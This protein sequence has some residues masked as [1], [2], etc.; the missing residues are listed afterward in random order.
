MIL[1]LCSAFLRL[2]HVDYASCCICIYPWSSLIGSWRAIELVNIPKIRMYHIKGETPTWFLRKI[3]PC[4][5]ICSSTY[6]G[7]Q[8]KVGILARYCCYKIVLVGS[9][10]DKVFISS[11]I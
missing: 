3:S 7:D 6:I 4:F 8:N 5:S 9:I 10:A 2:M 1:N 11:I